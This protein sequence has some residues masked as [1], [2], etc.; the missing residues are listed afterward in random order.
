MTVLDVYETA[1]WPTGPGT[2]LTSYMRDTIVYRS[3]RTGT[4]RSVESFLR[5]TYAYT[6]DGQQYVGS[7]LSVLPPRS[8]H[9]NPPLTDYLPGRAVVVH[10]DPNNRA[11]AVIDTSMPWTSVMHV[12]LGCLLVVGT[13]FGMR[14]RAAPAVSDH[15]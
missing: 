1:R 15:A 11:E 3:S 13:L 2:I 10:Y 8:S 6:V 5:V 7:R 4:W 14:V 9:A 12:V